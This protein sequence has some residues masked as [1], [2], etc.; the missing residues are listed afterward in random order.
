MSPL[1]VP[2]CHQYVVYR[3]EK[4]FDAQPIDDSPSEKFNEILQRANVPLPP[5]PFKSANG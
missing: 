1:S 3:G 2:E 5:P 4:S